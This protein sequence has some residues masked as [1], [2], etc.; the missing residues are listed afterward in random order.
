MGYHMPHVHWSSS[1]WLRL[2]ATSLKYLVTLH[3]VLLFGQYNPVFTT[4]M[5]LSALLMFVLLL[6]TQ[7]FE[8]LVFLCLHYF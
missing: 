7:T 8:L 4:P 1:Y 3:C 6:C 5:L 2:A